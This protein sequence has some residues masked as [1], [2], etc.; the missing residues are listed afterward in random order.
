M[1]DHLLHWVGKKC[2]AYDWLGIV[3]SVS[4]IPDYVV[5][6]LQGGGICH[7]HID[8]VKIEEEFDAGANVEELY[9]SKREDKKLGRITDE[10]IQLEVW[11]ISGGGDYDKE[12]K[13]TS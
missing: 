13:K 3:K 9:D 7:C 11:E 8:D 10:D 2:L 4:L 5:V 6:E 12:H 1:N